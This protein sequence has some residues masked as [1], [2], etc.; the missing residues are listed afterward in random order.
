MAEY[1]DL[2]TH[3]KVSWS[4]NMTV[5]SSKGIYIIKELTDNT[6]EWTRIQ[7]VDFKVKL[8]KKLLHLAATQQ[9]G[10]ANEVQEKFRRNGKVVDQERV[11]F[12]AEV[13][14]ARRGQPLMDDQQ[15]V[16][17]RCMELL[18]DGGDDGW[19]VLE[20]PCPDVEM[21]MK[22]IPPRN[23]ERSIATGKAVGVVDSSAEE[24]AAWLM[25][26]CNNERMRI[27]REEGNFARVML[28]EKARVNEVTVATVKKMPIYLTNREFVTRMMWKSEEGK[29]WI[30]IESVDDVVDYGYKPWITRGFTRALYEIENI[31][32][33]GE[34]KQVRQRCDV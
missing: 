6:C 20:S 16:F 18:G 30:A 7:Q 1:N 21:W 2:V 12:L 8:P 29:V 17:D 32:D 15:E 28:R 13:M 4:L 23:G 34:V 9:L 24:V 5:G 14:R 25:D 19:E 3:H 11:D 22:Y 31:V 10:W 27:S 33:Q 26:Y